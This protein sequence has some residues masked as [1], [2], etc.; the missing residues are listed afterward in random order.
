MDC[1]KL[2]S[3]VRQYSIPLIAGIVAAIIF[4][5]VD[6][7]NYEYLFGTDANVSHFELFDISLF[8]YHITSFPFLINDGFMVFFFGFACKGI[9][10]SLLPPNGSMY[11]ISRAATPSS[12]ACLAS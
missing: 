8:G 4:A 10:E 9:L 3:Q 5:N 12:A 1:R 6:E 2:D 11:P 7:E